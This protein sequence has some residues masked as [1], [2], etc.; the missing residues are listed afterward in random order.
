M[1]CIT[2]PT[3]HYDI[4]R[5]IVISNDDYKFVTY[6]HNILHEFT[7]D[8]KVIT[9]GPLQELSGRCMLN[10]HVFM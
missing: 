8:N 3:I 4:P 2:F 9:R 1:R 7:T 5:Q 6:P 10:I